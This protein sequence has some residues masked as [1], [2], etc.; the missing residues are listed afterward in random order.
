METD[1]HKALAQL[2]GSLAKL[3]SAREQVEQVTAGGKELTGQTTVL[4]GEAGQ[5]VG[6]LNTEIRELMELFAGKMSASEEHINRVVE[7]LH[8]SAEETLLQVTQEQKGQLNNFQVALDGK[9]G[10]TLTEFRSKLLQFETS[11]QKLVRESSIDINKK[12][13]AFAVSAQEIKTASTS[14]VEEV[15][16]LTANVL[17]EQERKVNVLLAQLKETDRQ[18]RALLGY[19]REQDL[20]AKWLSLESEM[21]TFRQEMLQNLAAADAR[22]E[23]LHKGQTR[24]FYA[25]VAIGLLLLVLKFV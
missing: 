4:L 8:T 21:K 1:I 25:L 18:V 10:Q 9:L 23:T 5:L 7:E 11:V 14:A 24:L 16:G 12:L 2:Q 13:E 17:T 3:Q 22:I 19:I 20:A 15:T 6:T